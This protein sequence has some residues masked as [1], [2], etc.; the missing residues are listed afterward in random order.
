MAAHYTR[1]V[2]S[3]CLARN[4]WMVTVEDARGRY[5]TGEGRNKVEAIRAASEK[6]KRMDEESNQ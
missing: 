6:L 1:V 5:A 2:A 4:L 3:K